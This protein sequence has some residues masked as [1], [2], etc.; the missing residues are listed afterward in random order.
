MKN[1]RK[2][3][4][5]QNRA[6]MKKRLKNLS[7]LKKIE[8]R[9]DRR[10][11]PRKRRQSKKLKRMLMK[12]RRKI[13]VPRLRR[14]QSTLSSSIMTIGGKSSKKLLRTRYQSDLRTTRMKAIKIKPKLMSRWLKFSGNSSALLIT[15]ICKQSTLIPSV[16]CCPS[17]E[18]LAF[19]ISLI[20]LALTQS[21]HRCSLTKKTGRISPNS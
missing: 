19:K 10:L 1:S 8:F 21:C 9:K 2:L 13:A 15:M 18:N 4:R 5:V 17:R 6:K 12:T 14:L 3:L 7:Q 11:L 20:K 16:I